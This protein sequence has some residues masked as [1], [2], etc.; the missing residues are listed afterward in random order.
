MILAVQGG[1]TAEG[2]A[3]FIGR[4]EHEG[5]FVIGKVQPSHGSL[6]VGFGGREV[7]FRDFEVLCIKH[8]P[9]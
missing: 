3:L 6:Y 7:P 9:L 1:A 8:L 2:E 5:S 4:H